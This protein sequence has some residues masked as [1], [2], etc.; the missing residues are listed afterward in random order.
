[1]KISRQFVVALLI[2][3]VFA[4]LELATMAQKP[5]DHKTQKVS[6]IAFISS[7]YDPA[8]MPPAWLLAAEIYLMNPDGTNVR[9]ITQTRPERTSLPY[10][11][12]ASG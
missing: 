4:G 3:G 2:T 8:L 7:R 10:L 1:M 5:K 6:T 12:T 11:L 9:R